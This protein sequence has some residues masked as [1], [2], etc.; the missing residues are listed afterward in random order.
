MNIHPTAI[1]SPH[2]RLEQ[3]VS[4]GPYVIIEDYV[5]IGSGSEINSHTVIKAYTTLGKGNRVYENAVLGGDPQDIKFKREA[6]A[7]I[8]GDDNVIREGVTI[9]RATGEGQATR[10]GSRNF[11]M[12]GTHI[13]H[14][15]E[16]GD[17]TIF[18]N[19]VA[20]A[21]HVLVE[22][23]AYL[24]AFA[25][26]HQFTRI[27][28]LAFIRA[29][30]KIVQDALPFCMIDSN[31]TRIRGLNVIG[32]R[33]SGFTAKDRQAIK[34]AYRLLLYTGLP[35]QEALQKAE[36]IDNEKVSYLINFIRQSKRGFI[37][38][39]REDEETEDI[40]TDEE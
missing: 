16:V 22:D 3:N 19:G 1:I 25:V 32:L 36:E 40:A 17:D 8:I 34:E 5:T 2:A 23:R 27:G 35:L 4:I 20:L 24:S 13:A 9:H 30:S 14:N 6:T 12:V 15:C 10:I 28:K 21:G 11:L 39:L 18:A 31:P 37:R 7:L 26:V 33:R 38:A 29:E